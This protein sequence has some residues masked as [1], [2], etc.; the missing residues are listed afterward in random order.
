V[1]TALSLTPVGPRRVY[2]QAVAAGFEVAINTGSGNDSTAWTVIGNKNG[3]HFSGLWN[4]ARAS[5]VKNIGLWTWNSGEDVRK[6]SLTE[7]R[8]MMERA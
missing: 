4:Q 2:D 3:M 7:L 1:T 6:V 5:G 8:V